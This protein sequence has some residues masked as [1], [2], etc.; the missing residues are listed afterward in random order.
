MVG[1]PGFVYVK[2]IFPSEVGVGQVPQPGAPPPPPAP[3]ADS[4]DKGGGGGGGGG[5]RGDLLSAIAGGAKLKKTKTVD[6][7][8][9]PGAVPQA[10]AE[11]PPCMVAAESWCQ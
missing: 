5:G 4:G 10:A 9:V 2:T 1:L 8:G 3:A 7:S 6:K 11:P